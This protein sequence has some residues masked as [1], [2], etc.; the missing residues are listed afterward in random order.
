MRARAENHSDFQ[1]WKTNLEGLAFHLNHWL[2]SATHN[3]EADKAHLL[4]PHA[5]SLIHHL[6]RLG[7]TSGRVPLLIGNLANVYAVTNDLD[8]AIGLLKTELQYLLNAEKPDEFL[9][10]QARLHLAQAL[11]AGEQVDAARAAEAAENLEHIAI[12]SQRLAA[13]ADTH[14]A[15]SHFCSHSQDVL[16]KIAGT[17]HSPEI[18]RPL[19]EVFADMLRR[20][21]RRGISR[22]RSCK[23]GQ[24]TSLRWPTR[25]SGACLPPSPHAIARRVKP[26]ARNPPPANRGSHPSRK[27]G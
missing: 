4:V 16:N 21:P 26:T 19:A 14:Q 13:E 27:V 18:S 6:Q 17:A 25:G 20:V 23:S 9:V 24:R 15:A 22:R 7:L 5:D 3:G 1:T 8:T 12:Y 10:N 11:V 2:T